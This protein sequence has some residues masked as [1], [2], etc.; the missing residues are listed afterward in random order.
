MIDY[1]SYDQ[2]V[3]VSSDGDFACLAKHLQE[4]NKLSIVLAP[5]PAS[6]SILLK[7]ATNRISYLEHFKNKISK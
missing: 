3:I 6:T 7:R 5:H 2:A 4:N 1:N